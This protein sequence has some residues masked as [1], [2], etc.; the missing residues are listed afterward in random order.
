METIRKHYDE[1]SVTYR[2]T[3]QS[4]VFK[5][6]DAITWKFLEPLVPTDP[7]SLV[8]DAGGGTGIWTIPMA[9][10]G[11]KVVLLD[12]SERMLEE[13]RKEVQIAGLQDRI[14]IRKA[15]MRNLDYPDETFDLVLSEHT[16]FLFK[17]PNQV[18]AELVR[19]LKKDAPIVLSAQNKLIQVLAHL[20][21]DPTK[22]PDI[23]KTAN[24]ILNKKEYDLLSKE[25]AIKIFSLTP[26]E[27][28]D[29]LERNGLKIERIF[30]KLVTMPLRF[31]P[32]FFMQTD[33]PKEIETNILQLELA[34]SDLSATE[35]LGAH[36]QAIA[37]KR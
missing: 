18:V 4:L 33:I 10:K 19:V 28:Q 25:K 12:I 7:N 11:C 24:R 34:F 3:R 29:I 14:E 23:I 35:V 13:A 5:I 20:P 2:I 21:N 26:Q 32:N 15:D 17:E 22:N 36:L 6:Y 9:R 16:L 37:R 27:F 8:L 31:E 30:P 1:K